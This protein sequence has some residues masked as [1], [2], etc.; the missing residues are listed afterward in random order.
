MYAM[1]EHRNAD[2]EVHSDTVTFGCKN[3]NNAHLS[4]QIAVII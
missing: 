4:D 3:S 1:P 2:V